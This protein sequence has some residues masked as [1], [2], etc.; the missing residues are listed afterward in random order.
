M[1]IQRRTTYPRHS[2]ASLVA[3]VVALVVCLA[4]ASANPASAQ[5][6]AAAQHFPVA[7]PA[8][9]AQEGAPHGPKAAWLKGY[10]HQIKAAMRSPIRQVR[11][12]A[13]VTLITLL[14]RPGYDQALKAPEMADALVP[15]LLT[16]YADARRPAERQMAATAVCLIGKEKHGIETLIALSEKD[17]DRFVQRRAR[18]AIASHYVR[19]YPELGE[20]LAERQR[21]GK[22]LLITRA[23]IERAKRRQARAQRLAA[24][25]AQ[26]EEEVILGVGKEQGE[27]Q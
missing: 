10:P 6:A 13:L 20:R 3:A 12:T 23:Q 14:Q 24:K 4:V 2:H 16:V 26:A 27:Q 7:Q 5:T 15:T 17:R 9:D 1:T 11:E 8:A 22:R 18:H 21:K 19:T 25:A